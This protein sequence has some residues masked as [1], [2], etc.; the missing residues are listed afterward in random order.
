M[1]TRT[2]LFQIISSCKIDI[3]FL[4]SAARRRYLSPYASIVLEQNVRT[5]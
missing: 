1:A 3:P 5:Y 2:S 4:L